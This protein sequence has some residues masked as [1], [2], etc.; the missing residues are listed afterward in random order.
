MI[1][2]IDF[3]GT[4]CADKY[5]DIGAPNYG[6]INYAIRLQKVHGHKI[7]L[8]TCRSGEDL[9]AAVAWCAVH[10]LIFDAVNANLPKNVERFGNDSRKVYADYYLDD[11]NI[12]LRSMR[13][14]SFRAGG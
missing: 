14:R 12:T 6:V 13:E 8:W 7:I 3:D 9:D 2:A 4:L 11:K 1:Y 5:P 10:G